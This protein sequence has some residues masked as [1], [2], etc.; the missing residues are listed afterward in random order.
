MSIKLSL[1]FAAIIFFTLG[2]AEMHVQDKPCHD[3]HA[4][5]IYPPIESP[6]NNTAAGAAKAFVNTSAFH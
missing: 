1:V 3:F 6:F 2:I 5:V 4:V